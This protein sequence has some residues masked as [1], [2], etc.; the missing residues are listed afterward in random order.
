MTRIDCPLVASMQSGQS[1][2]HGAPTFELPLH[3]VPTKAG[4]FDANGST[5]TFRRVVSSTPYVSTR[6]QFDATFFFSYFYLVLE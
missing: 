4:R 6:G 2:L 3:A 1:M 5:P